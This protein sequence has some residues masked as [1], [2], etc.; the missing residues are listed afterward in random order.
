MNNN[1]VGAQG[2]ES[3]YV[4]GASVEVA[5]HCDVPEYIY[6]DYSQRLFGKTRQEL[7]DEYRATYCVPLNSTSSIDFSYSSS[8]PNSGTYS[9]DST[10]SFMEGFEEFA[11]STSPVSSFDEVLR[12]NGLPTY[13]E[14][15]KQSGLDNI[16]FS[17]MP[18]S[19]SNVSFSDMPTGNSTQF[20]G[21]PIETWES[22]QEK[23]GSGNSDY[24]LDAITGGFLPLTEADSNLQDIGN[25]NLADAINIPGSVPGNRLTL[26]NSNPVFT[27]DPVSPQNSNGS[28]PYPKQPNFNIIT[29][30]PGNTFVIPNTETSLPDNS[31]QGSPTPLQTTGAV[32]LPSS[33]TPGNN[34]SFSLNGQ[35][36]PSLPLH[37]TQPNP[38]PSI[39]QPPQPPQSIVDEL[40]PHDS[41]LFKLAGA[42]GESI[43]D[44]PNLALWINE[45]TKDPSNVDFSDAL[46]PLNGIGERPST[47]NGLIPGANVQ[48]SPVHRRDIPI[49]NPALENLGV[50]STIQ[51]PFSATLEELQQVAP[52]L[53][54]T[55][56][57][58]SRFE[59]F[60]GNSALGSWREN[61]TTAE[62][63]GNLFLSVLPIVGPIIDI[64]DALAH[65]WYMYQ[66]DDW[67]NGYRWAGIA[68]SLIG[69]IPGAGDA[70]K[71]VGMSILDGGLALAKSQADQIWRLL[72]RV[73]PEWQDIDKL[74]E[75]FSGIFNDSVISSLILRFDAELHKLLKAITR[76][77]DEF[78]LLVRDLEKRRVQ[79]LAR[80]VEEFRNE[81]Q[82]WSEILAQLRRSIT[83]EPEFA[84]P[85]GMTIP[86][87]L[88][89]RNVDDALENTVHRSSSSNPNGNGGTNTGNTGGGGA[90]GEI[91]GNASWRKP[92]IPNLPNYADLPRRRPNYLT[93]PGRNDRTSAI[94]EFGDGQSIQIR[95]GSPAPL[96][97]QIDRANLSPE[98]QEVIH[99]AEGHAAAIMRANNIDQ[100]TLHINYV[101]GPCKLCVPAIG[102][103]LRP[104][105]RLYI[106]YPLE[107]GIG[108]GRGYFE[109]GTSG[110]INSPIE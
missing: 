8:F 30:P 45:L 61:P 11:P 66:N 95:S 58:L 78:T 108:V 55:H 16:S 31:F 107:D 109:G 94:F 41:S 67:G 102:A 10:P 92:K 15:L 40:T 29:T 20:V 50:S 24:N 82:I 89:H 110:F 27:I 6:D 56:L 79:L 13:N 100:A 53:G 1:D 75:A 103:I 60:L 91:E 9:L 34:S 14:W 42:I 37:Q 62:N 63:F 44:D 71:W 73:N 18:T 64:S 85:G 39:I 26:G 52:A 76:A 17:D 84:T 7:I 104:G 93:P 101:D 98:A 105:Q 57:P 32:N 22:L 83:G 88:N 69:I 99:H 21:P 90:N 96:G 48:F 54:A 74:S 59:Q 80:L 19:G 4:P 33:I 86:G 68:L 47:V 87:S 36:L 65:F 38:Q 46:Q 23:Y 81:V 3:N 12:Q 25:T 35:P 106:T 43:P 72:V 97:A 5:H 70:I 49:A 51:D 77:G 2:K 28:T